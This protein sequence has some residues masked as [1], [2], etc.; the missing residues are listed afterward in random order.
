MDVTLLPNLPSFKSYSMQRYHEELKR[1]LL[2]ISE[3]ADRVGEFAFEKTAFIS[4]RRESKLLLRLDRWCTYPFFLAG[5]PEKSFHILDQSHAHLS[6]FINK[7]AKCV[8]TCH[9]L[10]PLRDSLNMTPIKTTSF[11]EGMLGYLLKGIRRADHVIADSEATKDDLINLANV[12]EEKITVVYLGRNESFAPPASE[13]QRLKEAAAI[14]QEYQIPVE[15]RILFH[16][17]TGSPAKNTSSIIRAM[18]LMNEPVFLLRAG[19]PISPAEQELLDSLG[20]SSRYK[21]TGPGLSNEQLARIYRSADIFVF[22]SLWE[23]FGWPPIEAM[24][25]GTPVICSNIPSLKEV[26]ANAGIMVAPEDHNGLAE[27]LVKV[28]NDTELRKELI[29][30]GITRASQ[31]SWRKTALQVREVYKKTFEM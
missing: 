23:G 10:M 9:D 8:L 4:M 2:S 16:V 27:S 26:M 12:P 18:S 31:F 7:N 30:K 6:L 14:R 1:S 11:N 20:L 13:E 3:P 17:G 15:T 28:L 25:S 29:T 19:Q 5:R 24:A 21:F 22:P